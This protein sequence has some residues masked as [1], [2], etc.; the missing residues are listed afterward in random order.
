[1]AGAAIR[2]EG[3]AGTAETVADATGIE[4]V[5]AIIAT[6]IG[7]RDRNNDNDND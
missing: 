3:L 4:T 2:T 1:M 7:D 6:V 5:T